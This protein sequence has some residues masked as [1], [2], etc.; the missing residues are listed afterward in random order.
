M[1]FLPKSGTSDVCAPA[2]V[3]P[4]VTTIAARSAEAAKAGDNSGTRVRISRY[5]EKCRA[6]LLLT[7]TCLQT[8][9]SA[10]Q[11]SFTCSVLS[12][13]RAP[14]F[15]GDNAYDNAILSAPPAHARE[16]A[17][18]KAC[19]AEGRKPTSTRACSP[20]RRAKAERACPPKVADGERR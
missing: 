3:A 1:L 4:P 7:P 8:A 16:A 10:I 11:A 12:R 2:G 18:R 20:R 15:S 13:A 17:F 14:T 9:C 6:I 19:H 5:L